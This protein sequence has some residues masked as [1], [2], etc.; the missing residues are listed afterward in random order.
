VA[1]SSNDA[2]TF[3]FTDIA[4]STRLLDRLGDEYGVVLAEHQRLLRAAFAA[5]RGKEIDT[6]GDAFFVTFPTPV[7]A[8]AAAIDAQRALAQHDWPHAVKVSVRIGM[9]TG[10]AAVMAERYTGHA[11]HRAAR[12]SDAGHGGQILVSDASAEEL[13][14]GRDGFKLRDLGRRRLKDIGRVRIYQ[15]EAE[16]LE[17]RFPQLRTLDVVYRRRRRIV[18]ALAVAAVAVGAAFAYVLSRPSPVNVPS[19]AVAAISPGK[20]KVVA[21]IPTG[22]LPSGVAFGSGSVWVANKGDQ[23]L[24]QID[25]FT[26][27][28]VKTI[29]L[30]G[31][32]PDAVAAVPGAVWVFNGVS[33]T[34]LRIDPDVGTV[35]QKIHATGSL[36]PAGGGGGVAVGGGAVW[37]VSSSS[38]LVRIDSSTG[39]TVRDFAGRNPQGLAFGAGALW[40]ANRSENDVYRFDPNRFGRPAAVT[41][42]CGRRAAGRC[43]IAVGRGPSGITVGAGY[44]WVAD[45]D[46]D[47][48]TRIDPRTNETT[49]VDVGRAPVAVAYGDGAIWVANADGH[50]VSRI[51]AGSLKVKTIH[52]GH[53]PAG[54][55][56][57]ER[58]VWVTVDPGSGG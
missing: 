40:V 36:S 48:V 25:P 35:A 11:V 44:V 46:D 38:T 6:Q 18:I 20:K 58:L 7:D 21:P 29:P 41:P 12:V 23:T 17:R 5:H 8:I 3:L 47:A 9:D 45:S 42:R 14:D 19:N 50:S 57:G 26:K 1:E 54:V 30:G 53:N 56:F 34:L 49:S 55:A 22:T 10:R 16:G 52:V 51:D 43:S 32:T 31:L 15:V 24:S 27:A 28:V 13:G 4:G 33:G 2:V 37:A 39:H